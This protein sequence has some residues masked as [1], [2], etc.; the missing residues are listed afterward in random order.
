MQTPDY[1]STNRLLI[2]IHHLAV[3]GVSWRI[4]L[5]DIELLIKGL[6]E[7]DSFTPSNKT[8]SCRAWYE[9]LQNYGQS[10]RLLDQRAYWMQGAKSGCPL[11]VDKDYDGNV[12]IKDTAHYIGRLGAEKTKS[13][14]QEVPRAYHT[15]INDILLAAL[16]KTLSAW[17]K[18]DKVV[19]GMEGHGRETIAAGI[20]TSRTVGWFT[21]IYPVMLELS[22]LISEDELIK[23]VKEQLR[24]IPDKG[25]GYG[26]LK[27]INK[28]PELQDKSQWDILFNY[29]GQ[30]DNVIGNSQ[31]LSGA[32][33][34]AGLSIS[35]EQAVSEKISVNAMIQSGQLALD[36][37]YS[38]KHYSESTIKAVVDNYLANLESLVNHCIEQQKAGAIFTPSDYGLSSVVNYKELDSF[39]NESFNGVP[40][41]ECIEG[42]YR[43][44]GLQQGMLFHGLYTGSGGAYTEQFA[45]DLEGVDLKLLSRSWEHLLTHHSILRSA[46][47]YDAF[48]VPVQ[49]VYRDLKIPVTVLD[50]SDNDEQEQELKLT[51]Y[52]EADNARGF[53]FKNPP[54]MRL[55]LIRLGE[56][57][58]RMLWTW[59][60]IIFDGWSTQV[61]MEEFLNTYELLSSGKAAKE[62]EK[63][64][65]ED[66][67]R[68]IERRD[69]EQEAAYWCNYL[70]GINQSTLLPFIATTAE[71]TKGKGNYKSE[72][73][74]IDGGITDQLQSYAQRH[75][76]TI[77]SIMQGV[78][79]LLL[80]RYT[81]NKNI[82]FGVIVSGRPDDLPGVEKRVG[83]YIN[84]LPLHSK[85]QQNETVVEWLQGLQED[86]VLSRQYQYTPLYEL[87]GMTGVEG[88]LFDSLLVFENY[89]VSKLVASRQWSLKVTNVEIDEQTNYPLTIMISSAEKINIS[90]SY[91]AALLD[92]RYVGEIR[93]HFEHVLQQVVTNEAGHLDNI[94]L[95]TA[96]EEQQ[97]LV[98]FKGDNV[99]YPN[100]KSILHLLKEQSIKTPDCSCIGI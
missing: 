97:L 12:K 5:E 50:F 94:R 70:K 91:N 72:Y 76:L 36:W 93:N 2:V 78:W 81:G 58:Y 64:N 38:T 96:P 40:G 27:Y 95:L 100:N 25:L 7:N 8:S 59:H 33:E 6:K 31:W 82:V 17:S 18:N 35:E 43:L 20:D 28:E 44:S 34:S 54:L 56:N 30:S 23:T 21:T 4:L 89:P 99:N 87:Q 67:I 13:L 19:I 68:Y 42:I 16:A 85:M 9:A 10:K 66:Y 73:L 14:L 62:V 32:G 84:T 61:L 77:N 52:K 65:F 48:S 63:D 24:Q 86:Q 74:Q 29:L 57:K 1:E 45:C 80:H 60:H 22:G 69:K 92:E 75:R 51:E 49:C 3:D 47:Y 15:Q 98:A 83:M 79:S 37:I 11:P 88:D 26:V 90:F 41:K 55:A 39:L 46:F 53:D 71:R